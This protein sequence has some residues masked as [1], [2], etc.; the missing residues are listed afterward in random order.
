M[1]QACANAVF[2][3]YSQTALKRCLIR[4]GSNR[5]V[6]GA[7][8]QANP[9]VGWPEG[10]YI[11]YQLPWSYRVFVVYLVVVFVISIVK[12]AS[13]LRHL[14]P[15]TS[16]SFRALTND[17]DILRAWEKCSNKVKSMK[18]IVV[19]TL[20]LS[21][22]TAGYLLLNDLSALVKEKIIFPGAFLGSV[23]EVLTVFLFG[24]LTSTLIYAGCAFLDGALVRRRE[25]WTYTHSGINEDRPPTT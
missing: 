8:M 9:Q 1:A 18:R 3:S 20:L 5:K 24:I 14:L 22:L 17:H 21:V 4:C 13:V 15:F 23:I 6:L 25:A 10:T 11:D 12:C 7:E 19:L 16:S 2:N